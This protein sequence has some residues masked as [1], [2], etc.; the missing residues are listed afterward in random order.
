MYNLEQ[1]RLTVLM[2]MLGLDETMD[3]LVMASSICRYGYVFRGGW[4]MACE[5]H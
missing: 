1:K 2:E 4:V 5:G 3:Q